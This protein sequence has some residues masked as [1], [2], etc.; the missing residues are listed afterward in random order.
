MDFTPFEPPELMADDESTDVPN[1]YD[2]E[3]VSESEPE[4]PVRRSLWGVARSPEHPARHKPA[5]PYHCHDCRVAK[6]K[7]RRRLRCAFQRV[8]HQFG[9]IITCDHVYMKDVYHMKGVDGY[10]MLFEYL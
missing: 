10:P 3:Y 6:T 4:A 5:L 2:G 8:T 7:R 1:T 9:Q